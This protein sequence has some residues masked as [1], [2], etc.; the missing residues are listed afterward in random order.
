MQLNTVHIFILL[1]WFS[2]V[3]STNDHHLGQ[4]T[5]TSLQLCQQVSPGDK[6]ESKSTPNDIINTLKIYIYCIQQFWETCTKEQNLSATVTKHTIFNKPCFF[7]SL[8]LHDH[9]FTFEIQVHHIFQINVTFTYFNL[10]RYGS[11]C[12][13]H[14]IK[15]GE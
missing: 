1:Y 6:G 12:K 14:N 5:E 2:T 11:D 4:F 10:K 15:V 8:H 13:F 3:S 9:N 7:S